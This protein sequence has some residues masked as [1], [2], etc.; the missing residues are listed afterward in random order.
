MTTVASAPSRV[1]VVIR[2]AN[3]ASV[4]PA[5]V[6]AREAGGLIELRLDY[7]RLEDLNASNVA[8]WVHLAEGPVI[9]TLRRKPNG[10]EF[11]GSEETQIRI[12]K[13]L[14]ATGAAFI[15]LEIET[16]ESY[17]G[18]SLAS[19]KTSS[20]PCIA[21]YHNFQQTPADLEAVYRRLLN[22]GPDIL[23]LATHAKDFE[24]NL[25]LLQLAERAKRDGLPVIIASMGQLGTF[26][27]IMACGLGSLWTYAS[28][29]KGRESASGQ[30][31][32][33]EL[34][35]LY[36]VDEITRSTQVYGVIGWPVG[37]SLSPHI[38]NPALR[39][40]GLN[41]RYLPFP[42][43]DLTDFAPH[44]R[45]FAGFSVTIPHKVQ[46]LDFVDVIDQT[47]KQTGAANTLVNRGEKLFAYNTD[48]AGIEQALKE[49][50][51]EGVRETTLLGTGGAARAAALVLREK[52]CKVTVLARDTRK[53]ELFA[54]EFG[55][56]CDALSRSIKYGGDLLINATSAGMFPRIDE[57]PLP[58]E[59][60]NYRYVF[61]MVYNPLETRLMRQ[62][63]GRSIVISGV[64]MFVAQAARQ[65]ELWTEQGAPVDLMREIVLRQLAR[66]V[67]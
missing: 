12:L 31:T 56:G 65:F 40:Q 42:I 59:A 22:S 5:I 20:V 6:R 32:A 24:D 38:H 35:D 66:S 37:H 8:K 47:V 10:G 27:R 44:L 48:V 3:P 57:S 4:E 55:F 14:R 2:E 28:L 43:K 30:F 15:D 64:E 67:T 41:A 26:S 34:K 19:L 52:K 51:K 13:S 53:A 25:R 7:L 18:G 1:C 54:G 17:L 21:S 50:F 29:E 9:L 62:A 11:D 46:I 49:A 23:K 58:A 39:R 33:Q 16:I 45:R 63:G 60:L 61:D 36:S